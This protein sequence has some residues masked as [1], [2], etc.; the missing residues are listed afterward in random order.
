MT[1]IPVWIFV[2]IFYACSAFAQAPQPY[3]FVTNVP[4][5]EEA[6]L[7][8]SYWTQRLE[9]S[10]LRMTQAQVAAFNRQ[11]FSVDANMHDLDAFPDQLAR[12]QLLT[13]VDKVSKPAST[14]RYHASS[15]E[16]VTE[17]DYARL[18]AATNL[19]AVDPITRVRWGLVVKRS[20]MRSYPTAARVLKMPDDQHL[21]RFQE[22]AVFPGERLAIL[23][24]SADGQWLFAVNYHYA[25][26]V[27]SDAVALGSR[28][29][30]ESW[31]RAQ[32]RL[33]MTG[34][35]VLTNYSPEEPRVSER[36]LEMGVSLPLVNPVSAGF[37]IN[38]QNP[39]TSY[40][41]KMP[42][43]TEDGALAFAPAL[44]ARSRDVSVGYLPYSEDA[45][46]RQSFKFLGERYGWGHD[47]NGR[48]CS[49]FIGEVYK[50]FGLLMPR[51]TGQQA[52]GR[53]APTLRFNAPDVPAV[54]AAL[55][56]LRVGDLIY[57]PGHVVM[58]LGEVAGE[59]Y[60]IH[61]KTVLEYLTEAGERYTGT[62]S[63]IAVTPL[64]PLLAENGR[65]FL[66]NIYAI[67]HIALQE[68]H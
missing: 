30:V 16:Q 2:S 61:D 17:A 36:A 68:T 27:R 56:N 15:G 11:A 43:R 40:I 48:D 62:L 9:T 57:V 12:D 22:T 34:D 58:Y 35:R 60:V 6:M 29:Q 63:G 23:H 25:A 65:G 24:R 41:V 53:Y 45:L 54:R 5:L 42:V 46:L 37:E 38:G 64:T 18:Q 8:S 3:P 51:N 39:Y 21:D 59:P 50:S 52:S 32:P 20:A 1:R 7:K 19:A 47:Y 67:K 55:P 66:E 28:Q 31:V 44:I 10:G 4:G 13:L 49:G 26:W 14:P 33:V